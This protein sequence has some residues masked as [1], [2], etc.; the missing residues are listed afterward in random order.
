M[1]AKLQSVTIKPKASHTGMGVVTSIR[2]ETRAEDNT[3]VDKSRNVQE[4]IVG[5]WRVAE[6]ERKDQEEHVEHMTVEGIEEAGL[7]M[8]VVEACQEENR[9][10][11]RSHRLTGHE[12]RGDESAEDS[13]T[14]GGR[15]FRFEQ[16]CVGE[17]GCEEAIKKAWDINDGNLM[18]TISCCAKELQEWNGINIGKIL[19]DIKAKRRRLAR[20][21]EGGRSTRLI[22]ERNTLVKKIAKLL[23]Q[24]EIYWKQRSRALW[25]KE[26]DR[27]TKYFH[28]KAGQR[29]EKNH[30]AKL[31]DD[32]GRESIGTETVGRA[33]RKYFMALFKSDRPQF[34]DSVLDVVADRVT[35]S[36]N[37]GLQAEYKA[38]E[39]FIALKQMHPLKAPG[40]DVYKLVSKVLANRLK[41]FLGEI[42][43]ENQ[44][45][46]TPGRLITDNILVA[47]EIFHHMKNTRT[48]DE[49]LALKLDMTKAYDRIEWVFLERVLRRMGFDK[50]WTDNLM[51]CVSTV[52][53]T[54]WVNGKI[55]EDFKPSRGLRQGDPLSPYLFILCA[56]VLSGLVRKAME[57]GAIRG[58][59][60]AAGAPMV[61]HL[62]FADDSIL[63]VRAKEREVQKV[64]NILTCYEKASGQLVNYNKTTVSFSRGTRDE[65]RDQIADWLGVRVVEEQDKYLGLPTIVG[66]SK[67]IIARVIRDK[68]SRKLQGWRGMLLSKAGRE[69]LIK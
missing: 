17:D 45:A 36:M 54:I 51:K 40:P 31:I 11:T 10:R 61:T 52:M 62:L 41:V 60:I 23:K 46:F 16:M 53:F 42:V 7:L 28:K 20:L 26:G 37:E 64:K 30:I 5:S 59:R 58:V 56:E 43:S 19:R 35:E 67:Q 18:S 29:K 48:G 3:G 38:E 12:G 55:T 15:I 68:L 44:S 32:D 57:D 2:R 47:F 25:L 6:G 65:K 1:I 13:Q 50:G 9:G 66:H 8:N 63:F 34:E 49:H 14:G 27:N 33:A 39:V 22:N 24:E 69:I 4:E 21:N